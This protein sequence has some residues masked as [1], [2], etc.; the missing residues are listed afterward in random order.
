MAYF[1]NAANAQ[2]ITVTGL[3]GGQQIVNRFWLAYFGV[4]PN[5]NPHRSDLMLQSFRTAYRAQILST[6][7]DTYTVFSYRMVEWNDAILKGAVPHQRW[8]AIFDPSKLEILVGVGAD[9]GA[10]ASVG[11][12]AVPTHETLRVFYKPSSRALKA[13]KSNYWRVSGGWKTGQYDTVPE[14]WTAAF[15]AG[16]QG[17]FGGFIATG[18][19]G[20]GGGHAE[21][22]ISAASVPYYGKVV[23]PIGGN[24]RDATRLS[25]AVVA[26][27]YIGTQTTRRF[28]PAGGFRGR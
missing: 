13:F 12:V 17:A 15:L 4:L 24:I 14:K 22:F 1:L 7:Y 8:Q 27:P 19:D 10:N 11:L 16:E 3:I 5:P 28:F 23:K 20:T 25:T 18:F 6:Y 26:E 9:V 2:L 21:F